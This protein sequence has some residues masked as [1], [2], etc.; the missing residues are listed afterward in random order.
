MVKRSDFA[1]CP[2][3]LAILLGHTL[4]LA[5]QPPVPSVANGIPEAQYES[6][7][8]PF[9]VNDVLDVSRQLRWQEVAAL[10]C[11]RILLWRFDG[12]LRDDGDRQAA[13]AAR[14]LG[15]LRAS[16]KETV[17][18]LCRN[19][20]LRPT[21]YSTP[22]W[23]NGFVAVEALIQ[24]GGPQVAN[25]VIDLLKDDRTENEIKLCA[26]ILYRNDELDITFHRMRLVQERTKQTMNQDDHSR[27][28]RNLAKVTEM[29]A[30]PDFVKDKRNLP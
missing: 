2:V 3:I 22:H 20:T 6:E 11:H 25:S 1:M 4:R 13:R 9:S 15:S 26:Q 16:D 24:I 29:L 8:I 10:D 30:A 7:R 5:G 28:V 12:R 19:L 18:L 17:D 14:L 21:F 27:F 23:M